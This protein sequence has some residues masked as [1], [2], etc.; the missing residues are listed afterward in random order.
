MLPARAAPNHQKLNPPQQ[1]DYNTQETSTNPCN[2]EE[3]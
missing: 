2:E 3:E 1:T